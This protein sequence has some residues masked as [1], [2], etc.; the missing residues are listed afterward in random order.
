MRVTGAGFLLGVAL[1]GAANTAATAQDWARANADVRRLLPAAFPQLPA[2]IAH[3]LEGRRCTI[4]QPFGADRARG[5]VSGHFISGDRVD[6][7]V[8]CSVDGVSAILVFRAAGI[9][10]VDELARRPDGDYLQI[11]D[12]KGTI[13]YSRVI[14]VATPDGVRGYGRNAHVTSFDHDGIVD[15]FVEK[16]STVLYWDRAHWLVLDGSN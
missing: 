3:Y 4:P 9:S 5:V 16:A 12:D 8:L 11:V 13:G 10:H 1:A 6:W 2:D 15:A 14:S 7:A